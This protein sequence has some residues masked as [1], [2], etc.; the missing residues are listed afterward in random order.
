MVYRK[1]RFMTFQIFKKCQK[2]DEHSKNNKNERNIFLEH[3]YSTSVSKANLVDGLPLV[4]HRSAREKY[5]FICFH[6]FSIFH[7]FVFAFFENLKIYKSHH[8]QYFFLI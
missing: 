3:F 6:V 5:V 1:M 7:Q 2:N 4:L 8:V